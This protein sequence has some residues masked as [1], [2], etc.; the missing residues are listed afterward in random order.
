M[1]QSWPERPAHDS[2]PSNSPTLPAHIRISLLVSAICPQ[3][4][5][6]ALKS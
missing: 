4:H 1:Q 2:G 6:V 3:Q 5:S